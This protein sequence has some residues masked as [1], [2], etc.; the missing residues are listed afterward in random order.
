MPTLIFNKTDPRP[1]Y[2]LANK[3]G[4]FMAEHGITPEQT[5]LT[6]DPAEAFTWGNDDHALMEREEYNCL[7][8]FKVVAIVESTTRTYKIK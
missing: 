4:L 2:A 3:K 8:G 1:F 6:S 7:K 5:K